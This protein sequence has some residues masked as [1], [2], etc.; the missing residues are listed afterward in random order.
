MGAHFPTAILRPKLWERVRMMMND[1]RQ[2]AT[3]ASL[4]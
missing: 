3:N 1:S 2:Y 4:P